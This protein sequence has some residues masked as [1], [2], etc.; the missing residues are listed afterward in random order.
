MRPFATYASQ[1]MVRGGQVE[2]A[3]VAGFPAAV[4]DNQQR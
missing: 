4:S 1:A 2:H 3:D